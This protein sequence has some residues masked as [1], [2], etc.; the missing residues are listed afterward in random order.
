M[1]WLDFS[2]LGIYVLTLLG[3]GF[4][5]RKS[6]EEKPNEYILAGRKLSLPGFVITLVA[7]WYGGILGIGENTYSYG[8]QTWLIFGLPYY[9]FAF[10]FAFFIAGKINE[11]NSISIPEQFHH[12]FGKTAGVVSALYILI[13]SSPAPYILSIGI[14][15][16]FTIEIPLGIALIISTLISLSY[17][18]L[19]G[20]RAIVR[21]DYFQFGLMFIGFILLFTFS[22]N[23]TENFFDTIKSLPETHLSIT[24]GASFQYIFAWFFI[25]LWTFVDP[26]FYQ[27]CAAAESPKTA[28]NGILIA[29]GIW[30]IFDI[31]TLITG[32]YAKALLFEVEPLFAYPKLGKLVLPPLA[33]GLFITGLLATIM[34]TIDSLGFINALTFGRDILWRIQ[35]KSGLGKN[36]IEPSSIAFIRRGLIVTALISLSLAFMIP[37]VVKLWYLIGSIFVPGLVIPF[38]L[39]FSSKKYSILPVMILPV[40]VALIWALIGKFSGEYP[41]NIEPFYPGIFT[42]LLMYIFKGKNG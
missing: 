12:R 7:T 42:S 5:K 25:G 6:L 35:K 37:S 8:I 41:L 9:I 30:F 33:Y 20:F 19:G 22:I 2:V 32:L 21:T 27:R 13:I 1:H 38:L 3:L 34:S 11:L 40:V 15:L 14:L 31:L 4:Y 18:W 23:Y 24:G 16:Q 36:G 29:V 26:G 10:I 17:T 39:S 28:Q